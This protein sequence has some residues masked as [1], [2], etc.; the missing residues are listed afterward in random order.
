M[1]YEKEVMS[2]YI[3]TVHRIKLI[4]NGTARSLASCLK[5]IPA[6]AKLVDEEHDEKL[7]TILVFE[8]DEEMNEESPND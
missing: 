8:T 4:E 5:K 6:K 2:K 1:R 3:K 7:R